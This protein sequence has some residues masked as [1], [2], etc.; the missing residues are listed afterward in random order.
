MDHTTHY[1]RGAMFLLSFVITL[2]VM[3]FM[4]VFLLFRLVDPTPQAEAP[5][6]VQPGGVYLP[7]AEDRLTLFAVVEGESPNFDTFVLAGFYPDTGSI[8]L[9]VLP[10]QL[11]VNGVTLQQLYRQGL[12]V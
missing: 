8:P 5:L 3:G 12:G 10:R 9:M 6:P 1:G 11:E 4:V 7:S 2:L